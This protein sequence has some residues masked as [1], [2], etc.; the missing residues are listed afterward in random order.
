MLIR[1]LRK[2]G[3]VPA[4]RRLQQ[5]QQQQQQQQLRPYYVRRRDGEDERAS[6]TRAANLSR[7]HLRAAAAAAA[8]RSL[9][10]PFSS[11]LTEY[12]EHELDD[13]ND[14]EAYWRGVAGDIE[15]KALEIGLGPTAVTSAAASPRLGEYEAFLAEGR[16]GEMDFLA[17]PDRLERR[18]DLSVILPGV[19]AVIATS[20]V[21]W[22]GREGFP[23]A[24]ADRH[25]GRVSCYAWGEDYH[26]LLERKLSELARWLH[27]GCGGR[28]RWY[29]DTGALMERT[30]RSG[31]ASASSG[32]TRS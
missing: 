13:D 5:Q 17:R 10:K 31:R 7:R 27:D 4:L 20:L 15:A 25:R 24:Q 12:G 26:A 2:G 32:R 8:A 23:A 9:G 11:P 16:H 18:A 22:P 21:Y 14:N 1:G 28:G 29:V 30:S 19:R 6:T 3:G